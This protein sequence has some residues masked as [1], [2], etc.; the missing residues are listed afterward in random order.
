MPEL[1]AV[2]GEVRRCATKGL[3]IREDIEEQLTDA[4]DSILLHWVESIES[5]WMDRMK[6]GLSTPEWLLGL[7]DFR[8]FLSEES[9]EEALCLRCCHTDEGGGEDLPDGEYIGDVLAELTELTS[10]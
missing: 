9:S 8:G 7:R 4:D 6:E 1:L 10:V 2:E 5:V 3:A